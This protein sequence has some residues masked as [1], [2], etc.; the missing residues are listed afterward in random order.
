MWR[1]LYT[2]Y[3]LRFIR[4]RI[5]FCWCL[6]LVVTIYTWWQFESINLIPSTRFVVIKWQNR[7]LKRKPLKG[8]FGEVIG[9]K[10][11]IEIRFDNKLNIS[12]MSFSDNDGTGY[13]HTHAIRFCYSSYFYT[14]YIIWI[15]P[16]SGRTHKILFWFRACVVFINSVSTTHNVTFLS[17]R[18]L[19]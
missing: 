13:V 17:I 14:F 11:R 9:D 16:R 5:E 18:T 8:M 4:I 2:Q 3:S 19:H 1:Q 15:V 7:F 12:E 10:Q 6:W